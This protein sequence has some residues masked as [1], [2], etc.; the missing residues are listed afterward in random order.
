L[1]GGQLAFTAP[2]NAAAQEVARSHPTAPGRNPDSQVTLVKY[3][4]GTA[5]Q[6]CVANYHDDGVTKW[7]GQVTWSNGASD[8]LE[9]PAPGGLKCTPWRLAHGKTVAVS[10]I[11]DSIGWFGTLP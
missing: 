7:V 3:Y 8:D 10:Y 5:Y 1:A 6:F 11:W 2:A 4:N 9:K